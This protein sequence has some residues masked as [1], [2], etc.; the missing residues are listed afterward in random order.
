MVTFYK[1]LLRVA[2]FFAGKKRALGLL[3][4]FILSG[5]RPVEI[6]FLACLDLNVGKG[7]EV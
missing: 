2:P 3:A 1:V 7:L 6:G 4:R 5:R